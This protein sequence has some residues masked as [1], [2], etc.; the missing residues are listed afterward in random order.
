[1]KITI[2]YEIDR[3][4]R[5]QHEERRMGDMFIVT[6]IYFYEKGKT[7][8]KGDYPKLKEGCKYPDRLDCDAGPGYNRCE[9]MKC[10]GPG[11]WK[12]IL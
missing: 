1:M 11:H 5:V 4:H 2:D 9:F 3:T 7:T 12:C 10:F 6:N 8:L